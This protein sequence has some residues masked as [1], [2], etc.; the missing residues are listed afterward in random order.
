MGRPRELT[1]AERAE[2]RDQGY[3]LVEVWVPDFT[4]PDVLARAEEEAKR[5][6]WADNEEDVVEWLEAIQKDM[7]EGEDQV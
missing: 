5:I 1:E 3:K 2:L 4:D 7:W 6:A